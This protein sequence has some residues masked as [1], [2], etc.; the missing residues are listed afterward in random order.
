MD[1]S[2]I[3]VDYGTLCKSLEYIKQMNSKIGNSEF[4]IN[5]IVVDNY[6]DYSLKDELEKLLLDFEFVDNMGTK[7]QCKECYI[8]GLNGYKIHFIQNIENGG[9]AKGNNLGVKY[10]EQYL[11]TDYYLFSNNDIIL[12]NDFELQPLIQCFEENTN[13]AVVGPRVIDLNGKL[14]GPY[15]KQGWIKGLLCRY[16]PIDYLKRLSNDMYQENPDKKIYWTSGCFMLVD[17]TKFLQ[18][19]MFDPNTFLYC[20]EMILAERMEE[21]GDKFYYCDRCNIIHE[22][23]GTTGKKTTKV[24]MI[25]A[26]INSRLYYYKEYRKVKTLFIKPLE[27][28]LK[29]ALY[30]KGNSND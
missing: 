15:V 17:R 22:T 10:C 12:S 27:I 7:I 26:D 23:G 19:N 21:Y 11:N 2:V 8:V 16:V 13:I 3:I 4:G 24:N 6:Q 25:E 5:Y 18:V 14:Q 28:I 20:E 1:I 30:K 9:Y 29:Y